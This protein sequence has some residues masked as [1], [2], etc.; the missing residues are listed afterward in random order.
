MIKHRNKLCDVI[1]CL[2]PQS[3]CIQA[4]DNSELGNIDKVGDIRFLLR[5]RDVTCHSHS[6]KSWAVGQKIILFIS[7]LRSGGLR[8]N[9]K[10]H[11]MQIHE[12]EPSEYKVVLLPHFPC[13]TGSSIFGILHN[14]G[15]MPEVQKLSQPKN[16][17]CL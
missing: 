6:A 14:L 5:P 13:A 17:F 1:L 16:L 11:T 9:V 2:I 4:E 12:P 15:H 10:E 3:H 7:V 8:C